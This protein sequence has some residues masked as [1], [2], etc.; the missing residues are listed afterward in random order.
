M[1]APTSS[2]EMNSLVTKTTPTVS[3]FILLQDVAATNLLKKAPLTAFPLLAAANTYTGGGTQSFSGD[4]DLNN[5]N[6]L[7]IK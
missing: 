5:K 4:I 1:S 7:Q 6:S 3:D 2:F